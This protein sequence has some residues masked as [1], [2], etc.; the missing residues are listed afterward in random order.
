VSAQR[1]PSVAEATQFLRQSGD[2]LIVILHGSSDWPAK[3]RQV[4]ALIEETMDVYGIARFALGRTWNAASDAQRSEIGRLFPQVLIGNVGRTVGAY[5][6]VTFTV[7]RGTQLDDTVEVASTI[8]RP[9]DAPRQVVWLIGNVNGAPK[10]V[11]IIAEGTSMRITERDDCASFLAHNNHSI[12][13]L[14]ETLREQ[15]EAALRNEHAE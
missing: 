9:G 10:I 5:Q 2:K 11:D 13:A 8:L 12:P 1:P 15:A 14:I 3:T 4:Q 7:N 6:G